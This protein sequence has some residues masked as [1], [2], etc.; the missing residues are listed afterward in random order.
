MNLKNKIVLVT[1]ATQGIGKVTAL[2]LAKM[3]AD[4]TIVGRNPQKTAA[5]AEEICQASGNPSIHYLIGDLSTKSGVETVAQAFRSNHNNL[6]I[7]VNNA[8]AVFLHRQ[9]SAD[10]IEMTFALN[11]LAYFYMTYLLLDLIKASAPARIINVS[12]AAHYSGRINFND[13]QLERSFSGWKAYS[14]SKLANILFTKELSR[15]LEGTGVTA[16]ALHP[17]FVATNFGRSNGGF[18]DPL[19]KLFQVAAIT[20]EKGAETTIFLASSPEVE[21]MTSL[22]F[23]KKRPVR[24]SPAAVDPQSARKL[25]EVSLQML[26]L[27]E[28]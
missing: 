22:Y 19:F 5:A 1:G 13:I 17:G 20:P 4:V 28:E 12:S 15:M 10:G 23:A 3:G 18:F 9:E 6:H 27:P 2:E 26:G 24:P 11:H 14:Q 16:N 25:W 8:G 21:G 7:L